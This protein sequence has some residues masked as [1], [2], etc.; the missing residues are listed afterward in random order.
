MYIAGLAL[1]HMH[2][3]SEAHALFS[4]IRRMPI[5]ST[6]LYAGRDAL[7]DANG[8]PHVI[9]GAI[10]SGEFLWSDE[11]GTDVRLDIKSPWPETGSIAHARIEF[12][13]AGPKAIR[14]R[15]A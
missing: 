1:A 9:Q 11:L 8:N 3:W 14:V 5:P 4:A 10:R 13:F 15:S 12:A 6:M 2:K 7:R